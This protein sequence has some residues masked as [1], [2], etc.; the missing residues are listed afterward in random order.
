MR[1]NEEEGGGKEREHQDMVIT[2]PTDFINAEGPPEI[3]S[4]GE[5]KAGRN[6]GYE[7]QQKSET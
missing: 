3:R 1:R 7:S 4:A 6:G 2:L 5:R